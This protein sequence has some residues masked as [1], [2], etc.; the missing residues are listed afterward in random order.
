[1]ELQARL[2]REAILK[3]FSPIFLSSSLTSNNSTH[4]DKLHAVPKLTF[5]NN[6]FRI[7]TNLVDLTE[8]YKRFIQLC[9]YSLN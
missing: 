9:I 4:K 6:I 5:E 3:L 7:K 1:M 8:V 2:R